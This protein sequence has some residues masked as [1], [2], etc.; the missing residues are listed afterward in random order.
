M[1]AHPREVRNEVEAPAK[2]ER[3]RIYHTRYDI[4]CGLESS[5]LL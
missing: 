4:R 3:E 5:L 1:P 2:G